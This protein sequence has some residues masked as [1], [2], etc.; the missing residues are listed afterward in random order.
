MELTGRGKTL[1]AVS[2]VVGL[3]AL[4]VGEGD[5]LRAAVLAAIAPLGGLMVLRWTRPSLESNR[6]LN[7]AQVEA[8]QA[9]QVRLGI[10]NIGRSRP[11]ALMLEDRIPYRLGNRPRLVLERLAPG[12]RS[13][14]NYTIT[15]GSRGAY[16]LGPL[17]VRTSDPF[18]LAVS[19]QEFP[20]TTEL[21]VTP[22]IQPLRSLLLP[23]GAGMSSG[24]SASHTVAITGNDD[25][26]VREYRNGDDM[27]R[28]HW[29]ASAHRGQLMVR[30]EE[31]PWE[32]NA[33]VLLDVRRGAHRGELSSFEWMVDAAASAT[34]RL[35]RDGIDPWLVT[36]HRDFEC[37]QGDYGPAMRYLA[38][39][40]AA[41][42]APVAAM[43]EKAQRARS[44]SGIVAFLGHLTPEEAASL[45]RLAR[46]GG[47]CA[48]LVV[49][50]VRWIPKAA[51][52]RVDP[53]EQVFA[54]QHGQ[55][56]STLAS[57]GWQ[58]I[59]V[60]AGTEL[61]R[62]WTRLSAWRTLA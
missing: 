32:N 33:A 31:Q 54:Q 26:A 7:P 40:A 55:A 1:L 45:A 50:P 51:S 11:A 48:A 18:G 9:T 38:T 19:V 3:T 58:V 10:Q 15:P 52:S 17:T 34:V 61:R 30:R 22:R 36:A 27:R 25:I 5:L 6:V 29:K 16:E 2:V 14:V 12:A 60:V 44:V 47:H 49:D 57:A 37:R 4:A 53:R 20:V 62:V 56:L 28:V 23:G 13:V 41:P 24:E 43:V 21:I 39:V 46:R 35:A 59:P 42:E 8:G